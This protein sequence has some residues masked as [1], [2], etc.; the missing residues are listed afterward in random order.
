MVRGEPASRVELPVALRLQLPQLLLKLSNLGGSYLQTRLRNSG[1][2]PRH[3]HQLIFNLVHL[4]LT[5]S[6]IWS[7]LSL[8][9]LVPRNSTRSMSVFDP[10]RP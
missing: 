4:M 9:R 1:E 6:S 2:L 3:V 10:K 7:K 5:A 8:G